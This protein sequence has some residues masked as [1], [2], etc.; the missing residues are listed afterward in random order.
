MGGYRVLGITAAL[1]LLAESAK[2]LLEAWLSV[3]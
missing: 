1:S 2:W 3:M